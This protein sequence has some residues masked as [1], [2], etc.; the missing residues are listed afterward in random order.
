MPYLLGISRRVKW[1]RGVVRI[2]LRTRVQVPNRG[3]VAAREA[4]TGVALETFWR[5]LQAGAGASFGAAPARSITDR[6]GAKRTH[7]KVL[8]TNIA[9]FRAKG[10]PSLGEKVH[11]MK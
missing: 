6:D 2:V 4:V 7:T 5:R 9:V 1:A 11:L 8:H 10:H 3:E